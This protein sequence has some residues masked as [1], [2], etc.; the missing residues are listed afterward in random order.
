MQERRYQRAGRPEGG[1]SSDREDRSIWW[2]PR[3]GA[4]CAPCSRG[5]HSGD[6]LSRGAVVGKAVSLLSSILR[7]HCCPGQHRGD[8][9]QYASKT[10]DHLEAPP[11]PK[12]NVANDVEDLSRHTACAAAPATSTATRCRVEARYQV[13]FR[14]SANDL[15]RCC[16]GLRLSGRTGQ[17]H[18]RPPA[19]S[20]GRAV[21]SSH[22]ELSGCDSAITRATRSSRKRSRSAISVSDQP[23]AA[24]S[25][26][27]GRPRVLHANVNGG[28]SAVLAGTVGEGARQIDA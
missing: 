9:S 15:V 13:S 8:G 7:P 4:R 20:M 16:P 28:E 26:R 22:I 24:A 5:T 21:V 19:D 10:I 12:F 11:E 14:S 3:R 23:C 2:R 25:R 17:K 18:K 1:G 6:A 27:T